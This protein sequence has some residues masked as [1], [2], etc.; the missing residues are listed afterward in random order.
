VLIHILWRKKKKKK[1]IDVHSSL[2]NIERI[3]MRDSVMVKK[4]K[5][6]HQYS[7]GG[8]HVPHLTMYTIYFSC[9]LKKELK[10]LFEIVM[11]VAVQNIFYLKMY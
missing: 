6:N 5:K 2:G 10:Y 8:A 9:E 11:V 7:L 3:L 4:I 1:K